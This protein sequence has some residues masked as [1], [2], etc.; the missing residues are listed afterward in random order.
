MVRQGLF[1]EDLYYR[2]N[3]IEIHLP[4]LVERSEDIPLLAQHF[5]GRFS[6]T[7]GRRIDEISAAAISALGRY[8]FPGNVRELEN[9]IERAFVLCTGNRI[10][11][12]H[13]PQAVQQLAADVPGAAAALDPFASSERDVLLEVLERCAGNRT[14]AAR[15]L[16]IHRSTLFRKMRKYG[17]R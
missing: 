11:L 8:A 1:R 12:E 9:L 17:L 7:T 10:E 3:V 2:L 13:L 16:G 5:M 6:V 4:P 14:Q 15:E